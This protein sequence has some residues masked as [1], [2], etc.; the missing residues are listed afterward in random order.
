MEQRTRFQ[1]KVIK[2]Y[3]NNRNEIAVQR[4]QEI[5]TELYLSE[6]KKRAQQWKLA[7]GHLEALKIP[8][9]RIERIVKADKPEQLAALVQEI[10]AKS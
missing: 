3:Y 4:L 7:V 5:A 2:N 8:A 6:G 9:A 1:E 10:V